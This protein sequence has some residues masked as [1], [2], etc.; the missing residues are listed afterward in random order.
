MSLHLHEFTCTS[1]VTEASSSRATTSKKKKISKTRDA[2]RYMVTPLTTNLIPPLET[3]T[4]KSSHT[5]TLVFSASSGTTHSKEI[6]VLLDS[7]D[8]GDDFQQ[9]GNDNISPP[10]HTIRNIDENKESLVEQVESG[11]ESYYPHFENSSFFDPSSG[12]VG[13]FEFNHYPLSYLVIDMSNDS[14]VEYDLDL[15]KNLLFAEWSNELARLAQE[16]LELYRA[17]TAR[18]FKLFYHF[19]ILNSIVNAHAQKLQ[20]DEDQLI[21]KINKFKMQLS[22]IMGLNL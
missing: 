11:S 9:V 5:S 15:P 19:E 3:S 16:E 10:K 12:D 7:I 2:S 22:E 14:T 18:R 8:V 13:E 4:S 6:D 20:S 21:E 1:G 17:L